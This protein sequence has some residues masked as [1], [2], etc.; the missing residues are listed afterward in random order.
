MKTAFQIFLRDMKRILHNPVAIVITLGVCVIPSLY[1]WYNIVANWD[2]YG[3]TGNVKVAVA[4]EDAGTSNEYVGEMNAG[5]QTVAAL[6]ENHQLGWTCVDSAKEAEQGVERGDYCAAIVIPK[7]FSS[8]LTSMLTGDFTQPKLV[9]Y[10][11]QKV[12]AVAPEV[13][14]VG[15]T[16]VESTINQTFVSTV[17][18]VVAEKL[19][20]AGGEIDGKLE[21]SQDG[22]LGVVKRA[23]EAVE[24]VDGTLAKTQDTIDLTKDAVGDA[25]KAVEGLDALLPSLS[26]ALDRSDALLSGVRGASRDFSGSLSS[27]LSSGSVAL[28]QASGHANSAI[29]SITS[30]VLVAQGK[31]DNAL[32][33][34]DGLIE[35][36]QAV[37]D[38]LEGVNDTTADS[39][40]VADALGKLEEKNRQLKELKERLQRQSDDIKVTVSSMGD[41]SDSVDGAVQTALDQVSK[42]QDSLNRD[43]EPQLSRGLDGFSAVA[44]D[45]TGVIMSLEPSVTQSL[46]MM[47]QLV[48]TLD[49]A[50]TS[51]TQVSSELGKVV[52]RL[53]RTQQDIS[54]LRSSE[55][56]GDLKDMLNIDE[57][58]VE[59]FMT[60]PVQLE[61]RDVYPVATYGAGVAPFYTNLAIWVGGFVL[62]ALYRLEVDT[63]GVPAFTPTQGYFGRWLFMI[64]IGQIQALIV[65]AGDL[66][67]GVPNVAPGLFLL[68]GSVTSFVYVNLIYALASAFR[69]IGK[70][71]AVVI[72]IL[73]I[74]G[75]SGIYPIE[76]M[77]AFF[78]AVYPMLPFT[79]GINAM[80]E[81]IAGFYG[82]DYWKDLGC[83]LLFLIVAFAIGLGLRPLTMNLN[84]LFDRA[85]SRTDFMICELDDQPNKRFRL[86]AMVR[87]MLEDPGYRRKLLEQTER[88]ER[89]YPN[90]I[91]GGF[92]LVFG[93]PVLLFILTSV[94][95]LDIEGKIVMLVLWIVAI[96]LADTYMIIVEYFRT[97]LA[98]KILRSNEIEAGRPA[99]AAHLA[100]GSAADRTT[101]LPLDRSKGGGLD[102]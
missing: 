58:S 2:P 91:R 11:N 47:D 64:L 7:D 4:N 102:A 9:Y 37:I 45:L 5:D 31:V 8:D 35:T 24:Q 51:L 54:A 13:T 75:A 16:T 99:H 59:D 74:P 42:V 65:C 19:R 25:K 10:V 26:T 96:I 55:S 73:Q 66:V 68:A 94:L 22:I 18:K 1:A 60:S 85:L 32:V 23:K 97:N 63:E 101:A 33:K 12:N 21:S 17:S 30:S 61:T 41:L 88:F 36:N 38:A 27:A 67:I 77:P 52:T 82:M 72:V 87:L 83:V 76:M 3:N 44:G 34:V 70:A 79:Y 48:T 57:G 80:R 92:A 98:E 86:S 6:K 89:R 95:D 40:I 53:D 78:R 56:L 50:K 100:P 84:L 90:L 46:G 62:I 28:G 20:D 14:N 49:Q 81:T 29:G 71:V 93:L 43:I 69:H 15:A 39:A